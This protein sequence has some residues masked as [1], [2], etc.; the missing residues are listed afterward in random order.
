MTLEDTDWSYEEAQAQLQQ[1]LS[2]I[3]DSLR[4]EETKKMVAVIEVGSLSPA[5]LP[6]LT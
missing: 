6:V 4:A 5:Y 3:A 1:D 2:G